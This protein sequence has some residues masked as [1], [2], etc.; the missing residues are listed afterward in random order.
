MY[1]AYINKQPIEIIVGKY[2]LIFLYMIMSKVKTGIFYLKYLLN[3]FELKYINEMTYNMF[4]NV[5]IWFSQ[6]YKSWYLFYYILF[7]SIP[8]NIVM[9]K[10]CILLIFI[11][12]IH[13]LYRYLINMYI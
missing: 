2:I 7:L 6:N 3:Y 8:N 5:L 4:L 10:L 1:F 13:T 9:S 12:N 11:K